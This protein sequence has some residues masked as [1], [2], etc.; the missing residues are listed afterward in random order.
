MK[1]VIAYIRVSTKKQNPKRQYDNINR[2]AIENG[3]TVSKF[4]EDKFTGKEFNRPEFDKMKARVDRELEKGNDV[5]IIFDSVSRMSRT[6]KDGIDQY[7]D[8]Y[9]RGV[10]LVFLHEMAI[11]TEAYNNGIANFN[12][13]TDDK[14]VN[15]TMNFVRDLVKMIATEQ[16][17]KA[18]EQAE[19][20]G[21][22][23][24]SRVVEGLNASEKKGGRP[25]PKDGERIETN[26]AKEAKAF[27]LKKSKRYNGT[28][29]DTD[30]MKLAGISRPSFYKYLREIED[31]R[32]NE[33]AKAELEKLGA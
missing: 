13:N 12:I 3:L 15:L 10:S 22:D 21:R 27:I 29:N 25:A 5:T 7:F 18:F 32:A 16:I 17:E 4:Y 26:K 23:I 30:T 31:D 20:E 9:E 33:R 8:W 24:K 6:A 28:L 14:K 1:T 2:Y 11:N 19:K